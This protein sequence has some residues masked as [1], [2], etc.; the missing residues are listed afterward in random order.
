MVRWVDS[1]WLNIKSSGGIEVNGQCIQMT[2]SIAGAIDEEKWTGVWI[3]KTRAETRMQR[4][5][6][7]L[8][9]L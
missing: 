3:W 5:T 2:Y 9:E 4:P 6:V 8:N 1:Y 7:V